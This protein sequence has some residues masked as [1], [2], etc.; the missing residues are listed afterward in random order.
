L[1]AAV[2]CAWAQH[3]AAYLKIAR[4]AVIA[5]ALFYVAFL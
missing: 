4:R 5:A 2:L 1:I 3:P